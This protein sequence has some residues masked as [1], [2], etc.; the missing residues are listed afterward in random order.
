MKETPAS[1]H[2]SA[3]FAL[4]IVIRGSRRG[5]LHYIFSL[6][7]LNICPKCGTYSF[8]TVFYHRPGGSSMKSTLLLSFLLSSIGACQAMQSAAESNLQSIQ[9]GN[10]TLLNTYEG[11]YK[12][13]LN[14]S[15]DEAINTII[16]DGLTAYNK[17]QLGEAICENFMITATSTTGQIIAGVAGAIGTNK[18]IGNICRLYYLWVDEQYRN[19]GLGTQLMH[20]AMTYIRSKNALSIDIETYE[21]QN[22]ASQLFKKLGFITITTTPSPY[23]DNYL[24]T[25]YTMRKS[26]NIDDS[27]DSG[28]CLS[29]TLHNDYQFKLEESWSEPTRST[30]EN[31]LKS[32][33]EQKSGMQPDNHYTI[34]ITSDSDEIIAGAVGRIRSY[35]NENI[36]ELDDLWVN[37]KYRQQSFGTKIINELT[38]YAKGK[39]CMLI[40]LGTGQWQAKGFYEKSGF[41]A[42]AIIPNQENCKN[43]EWY[44]M[45]KVLIS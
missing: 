42:I 25:R 40:E 44:I 20:Q 30:M 38:K 12:I 3:L 7:L 33:N 17:E 39:K 36:C 28:K 21:F 35:N 24:N 9:L 8:F 26:L 2:K 15:N 23:T 6:I 29:G 37:K 4:V 11:G 27:C 43:I 16:W 10:S 31:K 41:T 45:R 32:Y 34:F 19:R 5:A 22:Q 13:Y 14:E 18:N 1:I